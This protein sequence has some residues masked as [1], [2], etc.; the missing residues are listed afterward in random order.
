LQTR[1]ANSRNVRFVVVYR[2]VVVVRF[3][4]VYRTNFNNL[5]YLALNFVY[6][7][8]FKGIKFS[9]CAKQFDQSMIDRCVRR[10]GTSQ[11]T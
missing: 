5:I 2:I 6:P 3:V 7:V 11:S 8:V 4:V 1:S 9:I 10:V